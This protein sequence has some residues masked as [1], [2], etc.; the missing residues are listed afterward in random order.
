MYNGHKNYIALRKDEY[1]TKEIAVSWSLEKR[2]Q[3]Y[4]F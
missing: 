3:G 1:L 2:R 4:Q